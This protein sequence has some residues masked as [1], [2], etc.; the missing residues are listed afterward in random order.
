MLRIL[1]ITALAALAGC[2]SSAGTPPSPPAFDVAYAQPSC[3][4]WDG[5]AVELV[6]RP[7]SVPGSAAIDSA[8]TRLQLAIFPTASSNL[9]GTYSWPSQPEQAMGS[10]C[11]EAGCE[12]LPS[13]TVEILAVN[14]D[15]SLEGTVSLRRRD[16]TTVRGGFH[17][18]WRGRTILCG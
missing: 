18:Q 5:A 17:A 11:T 6:L 8:S 3:A 15:S 10:A 1:S 16:S 14:T 13:G 9:V 7:D 4:P 12:I 2:S